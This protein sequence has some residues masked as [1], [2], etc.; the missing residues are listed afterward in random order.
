MK[1]AAVLLNRWEQEP[2]KEKCIGPFYNNPFHVLLWGH[3]TCYHHLTWNQLN[4]SSLEQAYFCSIIRFCKQ[5]AFFQRIK[6]R[7][8]EKKAA[9]KNVFTTRLIPSALKTLPDF[10]LALLFFLMGNKNS[11]VFR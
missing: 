6:Q 11:A 4:P 8:R 5:T 10:S 1:G 7:A 3:D 2:E 9:A